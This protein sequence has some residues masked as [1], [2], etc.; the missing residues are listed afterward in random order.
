LNLTIKDRRELRNDVGQVRGFAGSKV[1]N[2]TKHIVTPLKFTSSEKLLALCFIGF[3]TL[4]MRYQTHHWMLSTGSNP[5][6]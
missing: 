5:H 3:M 4:G 6:H 2:S 1:D